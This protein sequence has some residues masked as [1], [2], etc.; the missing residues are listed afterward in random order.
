[1]ARA[2]VPNPGPAETTDDPVAPMLSE[3][4]L[5]VGRLR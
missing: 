5:E 3:R 4:E 1:M 2:R